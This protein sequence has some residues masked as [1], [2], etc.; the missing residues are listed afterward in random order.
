MLSKAYGKQCN[1]EGG[2]DDT[3][4]PGK[5]RTTG[6]DLKCLFGIGIAF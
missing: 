3:H 2:P 4:W 6:V 5:L 1:K